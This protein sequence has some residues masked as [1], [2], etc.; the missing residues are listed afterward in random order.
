[1]YFYDP[2]F[3]YDAPKPF[4]EQYASPYDAEIAFADVQLGNLLAV[5]DELDLS[6]NTL[7]V[8][9][10]DHGEGLGQHQELRHACLVYESVMRVPLVMSCGT[11]LGGGL[12]VNRLVSLVD[13]KPT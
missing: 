3:P 5:L 4:S 11:R 1:M 12:H 13:I 10:G 8:M 6:D 7:V 9:A 2:H